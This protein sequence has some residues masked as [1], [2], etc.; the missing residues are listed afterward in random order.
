MASI[1]MML[2]AARDFFIIAESFGSFHSE[3]FWILIYRSHGESDSAYKCDCKCEN[4]YL[5]CKMSLM[6]ILQN[7]YIIYL[8]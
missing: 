5:H 2:F 1:F 6:V 3:F 8:R 4:F 7:S